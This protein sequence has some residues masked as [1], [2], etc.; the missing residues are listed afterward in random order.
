MPV[1]PGEQR[2]RAKRAA[3][4]AELPSDRTGEPWTPAEDAIVRDGSIT[5]IE[6]MVIL[7]RTFT[8]VRCREADVR[9]GRPL[10]STLPGWRSCPQCGKDFWYSQERRYCPCRDR[11]CSC[12]GGPFRARDA[13][14]RYCSV[15]C[16]DAVRRVHGTEV[17]AFADAMGVSNVTARKYLSADYSSAA[18]RRRRCPPQATQVNCRRCGKSFLGK[19]PQSAVCDTCKYADCEECGVRFRK[20]VAPQR[21]CGPDCAKAYAAKKRRAPYEAMDRLQLLALVW[22]KPYEVLR[23]YL[24]TDFEHAQT[25][26]GY[27][28]IADYDLDACRDRVNRF[29]LADRRGAGGTARTDATVA[30]L[31]VWPERASELYMDLMTYCFVWQIVAKAPTTIGGSQ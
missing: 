31:G 1:G 14:H 13:T 28:A 25:V 22:G 3:L 20:H 9:S 27:L 7:H 30:L 17:D 23:R 19:R 2:R 6:K 4:L 8:S 21:F 26:T 16:R 5:T 15:R 24:A 10:Y 12:C 11:M 18:P 29:V